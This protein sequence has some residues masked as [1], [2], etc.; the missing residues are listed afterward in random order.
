MS[1][2]PYGFHSNKTRLNVKICLNTHL[3]TQTSFVKPVF[4]HQFE[5]LQY[6][7]TKI[8]K[9]QIKI[10]QNMGLPLPH[11]CRPSSWWGVSSSPFVVVGGVPLSSSLP[12]VVVPC[13]CPSSSPF[14]VV[15]GPLASSS[16][17]F[18]VGAHVSTSS[19]S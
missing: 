11:P 1:Q 19:S 13:P 14:I 5:H 7:K 15:G 2:E 8:K 3:Y 17:S 16:S 4:K 9:I 6:T 10:T 12:F 18:V